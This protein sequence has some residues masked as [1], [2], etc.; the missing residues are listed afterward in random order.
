MPVLEGMAAGV[1]VIHSDHPALLEA[2]G[3]VGLAFPRGDGE[4]LGKCIKRVVSDPVLTRELR[5]AGRE[6]AARMTWDRWGEA[7][8]ALLRQVV[9]EAGR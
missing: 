8:A 3:G 4:G 6:R 5:A 2:A 7:A 1:P 9:A